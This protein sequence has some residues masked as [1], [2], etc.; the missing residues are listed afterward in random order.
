VHLNGPMGGRAYAHSLSAQAHP[1]YEKSLVEIMVDIVSRLA[2]CSE[3]A[4]LGF[5]GEWTGACLSMGRGAVPPCRT[6]R[7]AGPHNEID[8][9]LPL[10]P[11]LLAN[12]FR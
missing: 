9:L 11:A 10:A 4:R 5:R 3:P 12:I 1:P 7:S 8:W 2:C 6:G